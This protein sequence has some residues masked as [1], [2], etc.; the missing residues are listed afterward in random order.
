MNQ[1]AQ[2][3]PHPDDNRKRGDVREDGK[4]FWGKVSRKAG[5][6][7]IWLTPEEF[8]L[9][10]EKKKEINSK[11]YKKNASQRKL[12][13]SLYVL[14]NYEKNLKSAKS[15]YHK[16]KEKHKEKRDAYAAK[17]REENR[18]KARE[19]VA[20]W[21]KRNK[22]K[23]R[24]SERK[25]RQNNPRLTIVDSVRRLIQRAFQKRHIKKDARTAEIV[26]CT[27][28]ELASHIESKFAEGMNWDNRSLWHVDHIV[29]LKSASTKEDI[30]R[31]NHWSNL[32][33]LWI[34][35]NLSKGAKMPL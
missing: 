3:I 20:D 16:N 30:I 4:I 24:E 19:M 10:K 1:A 14:R 9:K 34:F 2:S 12:E 21:A 18:P 29:P 17:W 22:K 28:D 6:D 23:I 31:L 5:F 32:Q 25:R 27:W 15:S 35:D 7:F 13:R 8:F 26:G 11:S 33:P